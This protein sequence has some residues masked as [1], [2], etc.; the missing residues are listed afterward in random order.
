MPEQSQSEKGKDKQRAEDV[1][2]LADAL[3]LARLSPPKPTNFRVGCVLVA[4]PSPIP[5][6]SPSH[7]ADESDVP[8]KGKGQGHDSS[9][10]KREA[11][12]LA[13]GYTLELAGNTH[14]EQNALAKLAARHNLPE[15]RLHECPEFLDPA[16]RVTLYTTLEPCAKRLSG[17]KPCVE[18][19]LATR[20]SGGGGVHRVVYGA[21]E[22][23]TFVQK[24]AAARILEEAGVEIDYVGDLEGEILRIAM[25]GHGN[26]A[27]ENNPRVQAEA[28]PQS[29]P[30]TG[31]SQPQSQSQSQSH[32]QS[33]PTGTNIDNITAEER[34]RQEALP[35]NPKKRMMEV[36]IPRQ[37]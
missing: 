29:E 7:Q 2:Y 22:P 21:R 17:N 16:A 34:R 28:E 20:S 24:S 10:G 13:T 25:E 6:P 23:D 27:A 19:I 12:V 14:A 4:V 33:Q 30:P 5:I 18:R 11:Q 31:Q 8:R 15:S 36:N 1:Q 37:P 9:D 35:R 26:T 32:S 3:D